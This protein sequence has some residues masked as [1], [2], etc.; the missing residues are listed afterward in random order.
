M[1][2]LEIISFEAQA[3]LHAAKFARFGI[4]DAIGETDDLNLKYALF[5]LC[6][7]EDSAS[8]LLNDYETVLASLREGSD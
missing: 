2:R 5:T 6:A 7:V 3:L 1:Q 8:R 4:E